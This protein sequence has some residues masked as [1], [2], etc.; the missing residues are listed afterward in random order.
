MP[1]AK[2]ATVFREFDV[3]NPKENGFM[4]V[5]AT[6]QS[7]SID[8]SQEKPQQKASTNFKCKKKKKIWFF[9]LSLRG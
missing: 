3:L 1:S 5:F 6:F 8:I 7:D 9:F 4:S 2:N